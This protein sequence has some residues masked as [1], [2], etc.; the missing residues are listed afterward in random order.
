MPASS[1][2]QPRAGL[3]PTFVCH[4]T[5]GGFLESAHRVHCAVV[6]AG[7]ELLF[8]AGE[9]DLLVFFR[10]SA[11]PFQA[12]PLIRTQADA[13]KLTDEEI[14]IISASHTAAPRHIEVVRGLQAR[15]GLHE[16][17]L[18]CGFQ[19]PRDKVT[20]EDVRQGAPRSAI[21]NNCSGKHTGMLALA[22]ANGFSPEGYLDPEHPAQSLI[23]DSVCEWTDLQRRPLAWGIDGCSAPTVRLPLSSI[24]LAWARFAAHDA[25]PAAQRIRRAM[26]AYPEMIAGEGRIDTALMRATHGRIVTKIGAEGVYAIGLIDRGIGISLKVEDGA[27]RAIPP[28]VVSLLDQLGLLNDDERAALAP[29]V[30]VPVRNYRDLLAGDISTTLELPAGARGLLRG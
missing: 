26:M 7:G 5:R 12:M 25:E 11:K 14:A 28:T 23:L 16:E 17:Q 18:A 4:V 15:L 20:R 22:L 8:G 3:A 6:D 10:S 1:A 2:R 13:L 27:S 30:R 24:A 29:F 9:P 21:Y 19:W